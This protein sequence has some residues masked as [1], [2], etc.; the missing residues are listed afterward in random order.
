MAI[1]FGRDI[2]TTVDGDLV[3]NDRGDI[4]IADSYESAVQLL[5]NVMATDVGELRATPYFGANLGTLIG[6]DTEPILERIPLLVR[7]GLRRTEFLD[8]GDVR[9]DAYPID[10]DKIVVFVDLLGVYVNEDGEE[11]VPATTL[12]F[13]FPYTAERIREWS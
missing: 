8:P 11:S 9:V 3:I 10:I 13:Y 1:Y 6:E 7:E 2:E 5:K 12:K 4:Q